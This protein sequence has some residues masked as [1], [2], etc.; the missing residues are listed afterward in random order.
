MRKL[1]S[2]LVGGLTDQAVVS[3]G[4]FALSVSMARILPVADYGFYS[5]GMSFLLFFNT[6]HQAYIVYPLSVHTASASS[7]RYGHL[8]RVAVALTPLCA[9]AFLPVL[10]AA[11]SS[12]GRL[13]LLAPAFLALLAWQGQEVFRRSFLARGH[14]AQAILLDCVRYIGPLAVVLI[15]AGRITVAG[16][17]LLIAAMSVIGI[18]PLMPGLWRG[19]SCVLHGI[20]QEL[21]DHWRLAA[22]VIAANLLAAFTTQWFL[23]LLAWQHM[24][25]KAAS[26]V[27]LTNVVAIASPVMLGAENILVPELARSRNRLTFAGLMR[28]VSLHCAICIALVAPFFLLIALYPAETLRLVYGR[29]TAFAMYPGAL[30]MLAGVYACYLLSYILGATLRGY[31]AGAATFRM[32]LYPALLGV[33]LGSWLTIRFGV[34]GAALAGLLAGLLRVGTGCFQVLRLRGET[35]PPQTALAVS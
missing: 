29:T 33:T 12:M 4:N 19:A 14:H 35:V 27:A 1:R 18:L 25:E 8:L 20:A 30:V 13:S 21:T 28:L 2:G 34:E 7:P 31:R 23:W 15:F 24:P 26:L 10:G 32:Q 17:F 3:F 22:P 5:V 6:L 16:T 11:L 9:L